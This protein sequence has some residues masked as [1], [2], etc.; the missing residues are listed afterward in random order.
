MFNKYRAR[1]RARVKNPE[2]IKITLAKARQLY[3]LSI[4]KMIFIVIAPIVL[5]ALPADFFDK[6]PSI[7]LSQLILGVDCPACG[8]TRGI[9][10][11]IH[12][13]LENAFAYNMLSFI[14]LPLMILIWIQWFI[15]EL[16]LSKKLK[17]ALAAVPPVTAPATARS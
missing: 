10:H 6:G 5:L 9:M 11:L 7:C 16:R 15:K 14:V 8:L 12:M 17:I 4:S 13:D 1:Y 3:V 2:K